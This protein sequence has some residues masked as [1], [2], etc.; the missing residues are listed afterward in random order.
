MGASPKPKPRPLGAEL[1]SSSRFASSSFA[2]CSAAQTCSSLSPCSSYQLCKRAGSTSS[3]GSHDDSQSSAHLTKKDTVPSSLM[4]LSKS[5][6]ASAYSKPDSYAFTMSS[7]MSFS[8]TQESSWPSPQCTRYST[9]SCLS[10]LSK[11]LVGVSSSYTLSSRSF[12]TLSNTTILRYTM[13]SSLGKRS[14]RFSTSSRT[15]SPFL[16][17]ASASAPYSS[18]HWT[19]SA[20]R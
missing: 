7:P 19:T 11:M 8:R 12:A 10:L 5:D 15:E 20:F 1:A 16:S 14:R 18:K 13:G 3:F 2:F 4:R 6:S 17:S 9:L